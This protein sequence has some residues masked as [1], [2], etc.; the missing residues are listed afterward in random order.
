MKKTPFN[1]LNSLL[2]LLLCTICM[3]LSAPRPIAAQHQGVAL[4]VGVGQYQEG[5]GWST[6]N[7]RNDVVLMDSV[8]R[9][10][11]FQSKNIMSLTDAQATKAG[12][13]KA[14]RTHL[15]GKVQ[16]G[17]MA[18]FH[19][20][21]HGQQV[22]DDNGDEADGLD[23]ALVP[24]DSPKYY[25]AGRYEGERLLRDD[26]LQESLWQV[27]KKLGPDGMLLV[28]LDACHSGTGVRGDEEEGARGT[29]V[30]MA[31]PGWKPENNIIDSTFLGAYQETPNL[32]PMVAL[33]SSSPDQRS[34]ETDSGTRYGIFTL[35]IAQGLASLPENATYQ[36]L[37]DYAT[38]QVK[39]HAKG[40]GIAK[41]IEISQTPTYEGSI[42]QLVF[43]KGI[44]QMPVSF[45]VVEQLSPSLIRINAGLLRDVREG[46]RIAFFPL[47]IMDTTGQR[48]LAT[49]IVT[50]SQ[51]FTSEVE[52]DAQLNMAERELRA[53]VRQQRH[54]IAYV[55]MLRNLNQSEGREFQGSLS[56]FN[57]N[58]QPIRSARNKERIIAKV[59][60][61]G[62]K[63]FHYRI[64]I[65]ETTD[66]IKQV[67]PK[68]EKDAG[69]FK[70]EPNTTK[71]HRIKIGPPFGRD[72]YILIGTETRLELEQASKWL[73]I[74]FNR[75]CL[76]GGATA[77]SRAGL[78]KDKGFILSG[79]YFDALE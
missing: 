46:D 70:I 65:I 54:S 11:G 1:A 10:H 20:S 37:F 73:P 69:D 27:R 75:E 7:S 71:E 28:I 45:E 35:A 61:T 33:F 17:G 44:R 52:L 13:S 16:K 24:Y 31:P 64:F 40:V 78:P 18:V 30:I 36:F 15:T 72:Q 42:D 23:E 63:P 14:I 76:P 49:G 26:E 56:F 34:W 8:L 67:Y 25:Q 66:S 68:C 4:L 53:Y 48:P 2:P 59:S 58:G 39:A 43:G 57:E 77:P 3:L 12:I 41:G 50:D 22:K 21:G 79:F 5:S 62:T 60:N 29:H 51:G 32:A 19:F 55:D 74:V 6:L 9:L 47:G 38:P